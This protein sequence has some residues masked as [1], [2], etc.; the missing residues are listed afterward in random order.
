MTKY[1]YVGWFGHNHESYPVNS[2]IVDSRKKIYRG[3]APGHHRDLRTMLINL[4]Q[5]GVQ[6]LIVMHG[7]EQGVDIAEEARLIKEMDLSL[8]TFDWQ[9][10][11]AEKKIGVAVKW[12]KLKQRL[13]AG[14]VYI[15][16]I[17]GCDRSGG[18]V[19]RLRT[20]YYGW[21]KNEAQMELSY[22]GFAENSSASTLKAYQ[23]EILWFFDFPISEYTP[24]SVADPD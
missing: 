21:S 5:L 6:T 12:E 17:W 9:D 8:E 10:L 24:V 2:G 23:K 13:L 16:C 15:H 19:G 18:V 22:Y 3:G 4:K 20:E 11:V 1:D 14:N 7:S